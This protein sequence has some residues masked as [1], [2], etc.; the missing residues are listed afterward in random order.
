M[1]LSEYAGFDGLGLAELVAKGEVSPRELA[2]TAVGAISATDDKLKAVVE[3]YGDRIADLDETQLGGGPFRGVPFLIKDVGGHEAGR[4]I[5]FGSRL[6]EGMLAKVDTN[7]IKLLRAAGLNVIG[8][9]NTPEFSIAGSAENL[10][11]GNTSTPWRLGRSAGGSTGGGAAAVAA[12]MVPLAHG[13]DIAGSIR[14]PAA[15]SGC[16]GL[17]P[18]RGMV[19]AGPLIDEAGFGMA[20][21]FVQSKSM[22]DTA[23]MMDCLAVPQ[24][25]DP[26]EVRRP[27]RPFADFLQPPDKSLKIGLTTAPLI[28]DAPVDA[29][30]IAATQA[31]ADFLSGYGYLVE[32]AD[33]PFDHV[34]ASL[35]MIDFWFFGFDKRLDGYAEATGRKVGQ[36]TVE[37]IVLKIYELARSIDPGRFTDAI[38]WMNGARRELGAFFETYDVL[39][40]PTAAVPAPAHGLYGLSVPDMDVAE[41]IVY[42]D[43][44]VQF[45]FMYNVMGAPAISLPLAMHSSGLP[46]GV[47]LGAR[48]QRDEVLIG[49]GALLEQAMPWHDR[50]PPLGVAGSAI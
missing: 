34:E 30:V 23:A 29:E 35:M 41:Y 22:R 6:C 1:D 49:L 21:N 26:F 13:S 47:Q 28:P 4:K 25:G 33:P 7:F 18:S 36:D 27:G 20:M 45:C 43:K 31:V 11:Y 50:I 17:K 12:G 42:A 32:V 10:L 38:A 19:S 16:V 8:R 5:E 44:P 37:P 40:S 2:I 24:P 39:L 15:W 3:L 46:I 14:I 9:S 48:P